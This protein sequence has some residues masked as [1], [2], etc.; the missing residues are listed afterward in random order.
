MSGRALISVYDKGG[1]VDFATELAGMGWDLLSSGGTAAALRDAGLTVTE[2][3]DFTGFPA[4]LGHRVVTLHP[5]V[6]GG[7]LADRDVPEHLDE[8]EHYGIEPIDLVVSNLYP[9]ASNPSIEM[10]DVGGPAMVRAAAKN[11][12]HVGILTDP[13]DYPAILDKLKREGTLSEKTRRRLALA[14][15]R[16]TAEYDAAISEWMEDEESEA[17]E[18]NFPENLTLRYE[19]ALPLRY[20]ENPHQRAA[21][22]ARAGGEHLLSGVE[23]LQGK[24]LSFNNLGDLNAARTLLA[25][26]VGFGDGQAAVIFK[27]ANPCGAAVG[28]T[29]SDAYSKAFASDPVSA[30]GGIVALGGEVDGGLAREISKVFTEVLISPSFTSEALEIFASK[31]NMIL[32]EAG[33]LLQQELSARQVTG[34]LLLQDEDYTEDDADYRVVTQK[35]PGGDQMSDLLFA[36]RVARNVKSNA[37]VL[38]QDGA[39]VGVGAGQMSRVESSEIAVKK[40]RDRVR[41]ASAASDAFFPFADGVEALAE[42]GVSAVIQPGGSKRDEEVIEAADRLG[43]AMVFT[44]RRHFLH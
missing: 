20:G 10:I 21:Y 17:D 31:P 6:H 7:I 27:H 18:E 42:A 14:A 24:D 23:K 4:I 19:K 43:V 3:A 13:E 16:R 1:I 34:G 30:F 37:I 38:V 5:K 2:T 35:E 41:G 29:L 33:P 39:T 25:D 9:F 40:A 11:H 22:Y 8:M 28:E 32:L 36:W 15:F 44:G 12:A 26:L